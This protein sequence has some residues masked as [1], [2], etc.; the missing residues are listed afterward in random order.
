MPYVLALADLITGQ[1]TGTGMSS[2]AADNG[3]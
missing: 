3:L 2:F 1:A